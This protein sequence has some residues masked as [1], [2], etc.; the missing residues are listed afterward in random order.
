MTCFKYRPKET[1]EVEVPIGNGYNDGI[2]KKEISKKD[3]MKLLTKF[4]NWFPETNVHQHFMG[5]FYRFGICP[6][7]FMRNDLEQLIILQ[8]HCETYS[9][10][11]F[12]TSLE[13][14][15]AWLMEAFTVIRAAKNDWQKNEIEIMKK[16]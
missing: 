12:G 5:K 8:D 10:L 4:Y 16:K 2:E 11:P 13:N 14:N 3:V 6:M 15:P 7:S 1:V 9:C